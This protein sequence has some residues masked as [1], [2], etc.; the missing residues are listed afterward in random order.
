M[1]CA[2][3]RVCDP[4][5]CLP[6]SC[7]VRRG[8]RLRA[9]D[10]RGGELLHGQLS[11]TSCTAVIY[12]SVGKEMKRKMLT[13]TTSTTDYPLWQTSLVNGNC[14]VTATCDTTS[15]CTNSAPFTIAGN[16]VTVDLTLP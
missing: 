15:T 12:N 10:R 9:G 7:A 11:C 16:T 8:V 1:A 13:K 4:L 3:D 2:G 6:G 14:T 5:G